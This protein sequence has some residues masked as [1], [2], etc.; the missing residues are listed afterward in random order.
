MLEN[1]IQDGMRP[2]KAEDLRHVTLDW[3]ALVPVIS[4]ANRAIARFDGLLTHLPN[5]NL[6]M[7]P[8]TT[9]EAVLSSKIEGTVVTVGEVLRFEA[10]DEP[11][12]ESKQLDIEEVVNYRAALTSARGELERRP[13]NLALLLKL[14]KTL[15]NSVRGY[16]KDPG[17]FRRLQNHI[18]RPGSRLDEAEFVPPAP[19][20]LM[21]ALYSWE[22]YYHDTEKDPLVQLASIHA[23]FEFLHPFLDGNGRIGRILIPIFLYEKGILSTPTF[24]MSEYLEEH[25]DAYIQHLRELGARPDGWTR[26]CDFFLEGMA[27]Q[28]DRNVAKAQAILELHARLRTQL[29]ENNSASTL[30]LLDAMFAQPTFQAGSLLRYPG[31]P[32]RARLMQL[33]GQLVDQ[34]VLK[35]LVVGRGPKPSVYSLEELVRLCDSKPPRKVIKNAPAPPLSIQLRSNLV[36]SV[37]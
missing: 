4:H 30:P 37:P 22:K 29:L 1:D 16:N 2:A 7:T 25:R 9:R 6:L 26:W 31:V 3:E 10:G 15:L 18:G 21:A 34:K 11:V 28:A 32:Q 19:E 36:A 13:F 17:R 23:Q 27:I 5:P 24:Y 20:D 35:M 33:L 14:H 8:L 12:L